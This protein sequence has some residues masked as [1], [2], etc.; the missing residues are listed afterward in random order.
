MA[1]V[2]SDWKTVKFTAKGEKDRGHTLTGMSNCRE[3]P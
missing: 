1:H 3:Q 2:F